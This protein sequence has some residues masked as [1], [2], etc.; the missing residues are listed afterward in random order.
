MRYT[1]LSLYLAFI[2][3]QATMPDVV[4]AGQKASGGAIQAEWPELDFTAAYDNFTKGDSAAASREIRRG[5]DFLHTI[6]ERATGKIKEDLFR[7]YGELGKLSDDIEKGTVKSSTDLR[8][9]FSHAHQALAEYYHA[10]L[11]DSWLKKDIEMVRKELK[12]ALSNLER[13]ISWYGGEVEEKTTKVIKEL[14]ALEE[15]LA[16]KSEWIAEKIDLAIKEIEDEL[17]K[18]EDRNAGEEKKE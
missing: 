1:I 8:E 7:S 11:K 15:R 16:Q 3:L 14:R 13:S 10:R 6:A 18:L 17:N 9:A 4:A 2:A 5:A 12:S